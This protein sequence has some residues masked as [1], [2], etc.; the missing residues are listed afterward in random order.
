MKPTEINNA[1]CLCKSDLQRLFAPMNWRTVRRLV[2][3][4][5]LLEQ[6]G[7]A[8]ERWRAAKTFTPKESK[9]LT[10]YLKQYANGKKN[11]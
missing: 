1:I 3:T 7:I 9:A 2:F 8:P 5:I 11:L 4:D 10:D 6:I